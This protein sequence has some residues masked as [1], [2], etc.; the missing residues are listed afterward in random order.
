MAYLD[1]AAAEAT[2]LE[3]DVRG[4]RVPASIVPLPFYKAPSTEKKAAS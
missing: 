1:P 2:D 3:I 4:S